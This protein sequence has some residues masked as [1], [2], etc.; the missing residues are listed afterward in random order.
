M[1]TI[2]K[3]KKNIN[4]TISERLLEVLDV[5][6]GANELTRSQQISNILYHYLTKDYPNLSNRQPKLTP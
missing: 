4:I 6:A 3:G 1:G 2:K 5:E